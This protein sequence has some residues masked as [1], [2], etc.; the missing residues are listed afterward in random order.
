MCETYDNKWRSSLSAHS[1][2]RSVNRATRA[3]GNDKS[4]LVHLA[5]YKRLPKID[6]TSAGHG[7]G[8]SISGG[9]PLCPTVVQR[10][11][12]LQSSGKLSNMFSK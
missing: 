12:G 7:V 1:H 3:T 6:R 5:A 2:H 9:G 8:T 4:G 10:R 11:C